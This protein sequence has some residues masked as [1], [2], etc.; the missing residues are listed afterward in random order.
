MKSQTKGLGV[1]LSLA[2]PIGFSGKA[3]IS[4]SE[5]IQGSL[6][7]SRYEH[8]RLTLEYLKHYHDVIHSTERF[9]VYFGAGVSLIAS[10]HLGVRGIGGITWCSRSIPIDIYVQLAPALYFTHFSG[11][12]VE[13][14]IGI[15][16]FL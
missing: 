1:G 16:Y 5:A 11:F 15:R 4:R 8:S 3:W 14:S 9:P 2:N 10:E 12:D 7:W 6:G 13:G